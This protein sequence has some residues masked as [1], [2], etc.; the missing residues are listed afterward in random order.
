MGVAAARTLGGEGPASALLRARPLATTVVGSYS[1]PEWL[2]RLKTDFYQSRIS[3][4]HLNEIHDVAIK[5]AL[6]DQELA[7]VDIVS[8]G[9]LR[10][11]NDIDYLL[12][13][14]PGV[15]IPRRSKT[16]YYDYYD[17]EVTEPLPAAG[18]L[19]PGLTADFAFT[20][21]ETDRPIKFSFTG[22][23][24][25]SRRIRGTGYADPADLVRALARWLNAQA[26]E[27]AA[28]G[29]DLLQIDEPFLAGYPEQVD[30]AIE[31][32]NIVTAGVP[33]TWALHVCY[34]NRYARPLWEGHYDFLFPAVASARVDALVLEFARKGLDDLRL[35]R[36]HAWDR[37]LGLGVID[38]K[39][40]EVETADLV[41]SRIRRALEYVPAQRLMVNPDCGLR[42]LPTAVAQAKLRAMVAGAAQVRQE[43]AARAG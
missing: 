1:V 42:H 32:V 15:R 13:R 17:A 30:L 2:G 23:F 25:L 40:T 4:Q 35:L 12:I 14:I 34:G 16:D 11:D 41:A 26:Q 38:V 28:A 9:E 37:Y 22:P 19:R 43:L 36:Q 24:S 5:A 3:A 31:A 6:K 39:A 27:L 18:P 29:A 8:D 21:E 20:R 7:G 33:V 10:R